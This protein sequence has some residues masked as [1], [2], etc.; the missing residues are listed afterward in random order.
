MRNYLIILFASIFIAN[1]SM[2]Q[3]PI[4][5]NY[6]LDHD[7]LQN[8]ASTQLDSAKWRINF[9]SQYKFTKD[10]TPDWNKM[11]QFEVDG[12]FNVKDVGIISFLVSNDDYSY[13]NRT[14]IGVGYSYRYEKNGW[15]IQPGLRLLANFDA[16]NLSK[17]IIPNETFDNRTQLR[18]LG[19]IDFGLSMGWK[20]LEVQAAYNNLTR[21]TYEVKRYTVLADKPNWLIGAKYRFDIGEKWEITPF[22]QVYNERAFSYDIGVQGG[23]KNLIKV[24]YQMRLLNMVNIYHVNI[25]ATKSLQ[26]RAAVGHSLLTTD[27][28]AELGISY[29]LY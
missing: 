15:F 17:I 18:L 26:I 22:A 25:Q 19:D 14:Q 3:T 9:Y 28:N 23:L 7:Y 13:F 24:G 10:K 2:A 11:P 27:I 20:N 8:A 21:T 29:K 4:R 5:L 6:Y 16:I 1:H 12:H